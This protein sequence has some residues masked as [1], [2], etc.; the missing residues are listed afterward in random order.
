MQSLADVS[1]LCDN[2][3][4]PSTPTS[5]FSCTW[6]FMGSYKWSDK[7]P[8]LG[9]NYSYPTHNPTYNYPGTSKYRTTQTGP[10]QPRLSLLPPRARTTPSQRPTATGLGGFLGVGILGR[11]ALCACSGLLRVCGGLIPVQEVLLYIL[12]GGPREQ[13]GASSMKPD[14]PRRHHIIINHQIINI[15]NLKAVAMMAVPTAAESEN[16]NSNLSIAQ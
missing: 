11:R 3:K 5:F 6:R 14:G 7:S 9:Y 15:I 16:A 10:G 1:Q 8:N 12:L 4:H 2:P 13:E